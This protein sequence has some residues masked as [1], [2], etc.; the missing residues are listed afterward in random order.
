LAILQKNPQ[1]FSLHVLSYEDIV[2]ALTRIYDLLVMSSP[3]IK[4]LV[5]TSPVPL[6]ATF[7]EMDVFTAN[8]YSKSVLRS[9]SEWFSLQ[10]NNVD[11]FPSYESIILSKPKHVWKKNLRHISDE[12]IRFNVENM[13]ANYLGGKAFKRQ[14]KPKICL[15][16]KLIALKNRFKAICT[17]RE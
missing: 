10:Y 13:A 1:R 12:A 9:A 2:R 17:Q 4:I 6:H 3:E 11:Y 16:Q 15:K 14:S 5:T 8:A 7:R